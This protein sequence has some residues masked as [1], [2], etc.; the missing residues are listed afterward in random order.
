[1]LTHVVL[2]TLTDSDDKPEALTRLRAMRGRIPSLLSLKCGG[3]S[4]TG[5]NAS[6][7]VLISE[8]AD[9]AGLADY[10]EHPVHQE[11]ISWL[12]P[13]LSGRSVVDSTD[14]G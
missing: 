5:P 3:N 12:R 6:D 7:I 2:F 14:L 8:H 1:V 13:R 9:A 10:V 4:L 11:L